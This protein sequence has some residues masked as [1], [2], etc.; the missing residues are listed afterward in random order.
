MYSR[1]RISTRP[2][3]YAPFPASRPELAVGTHRRV[4]AACVR[5]RRWRRRAEPRR[6]ATQGNYQKKDA[7]RG[8]VACVSGNR[9]ESPGARTVLL[10][11]PN[12]FPKCEGSDE[13]NQVRS[14]A[15]S[16]YWR[17]REPPARK[18]WNL[19]AKNIVRLPPRHRTDTGHAR[20]GV[21]KHRIV[22]HHIGH[23]ADDRDARAHEERSSQSGGLV[24]GW[25]SRTLHR[26]AC[27]SSI[28]GSSS[29]S[30]ARHDA[31]AVP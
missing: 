24:Q 31:P 8:G 20:Q 21:D 12:D 23:G 16:F 6:A 30:S 26:Y 27:A 19:C 7:G 4:R 25:I 13:Q 29:R 3:Y 11:L 9:V 17:E 15:P 1:D 2:P 5:W 10:D 22:C 14:G 18:Y 28:I